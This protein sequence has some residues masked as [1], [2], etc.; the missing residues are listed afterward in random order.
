MASLDQSEVDKDYYEV[1]HTAKYSILSAIKSFTLRTFMFSR[2]FRNLSVRSAGRP[3]P[4]L[5]SFRNPIV[6]GLVLRPA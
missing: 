6:P 2:I 5:D 3:I 1:L 4:F